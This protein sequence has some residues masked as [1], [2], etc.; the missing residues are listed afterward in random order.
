[1]GHALRTTTL[2]LG[3]RCDERLAPPGLQ[4]RALPT[5]PWVFRPCR[6]RSSKWWM[7]RMTVPA[8]SGW[9]RALTRASSFASRTE[10]RRSPANGTQPPLFSELGL[11][12]SYLGSGTGEDSRSLAELVRPDGEVVGLCHCLPPRPGLPTARVGDGLHNLDGTGGEVPVAPSRVRPAVQVADPMQGG[13]TV[14]TITPTDTCLRLVATWAKPRWSKKLAT[15]ARRGF[16]GAGPRDGVLAGV[17]VGG[18]QVPDDPGSRRCAAPA[19]SSAPS[20]S[21]RLQIPS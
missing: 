1:M 17:G 10:H 18:L 15:P 7:G 6:V 12:I 4:R 9:T 16:P 20:G 3:R 13:R 8:G 19:G 11:A 2:P 21:C 14:A 5:S